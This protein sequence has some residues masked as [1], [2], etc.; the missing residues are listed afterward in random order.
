ML[1]ALHDG[2]RCPPEVGRLHVM[3]DRVRLYVMGARVRLLVM[4]SASRYST[5]PVMIKGCVVKD[6]A[7]VHGR[8]C[9]TR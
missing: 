7:I 1:W 9:R 4:G 8:M 5:S 6:E 2:P 3:G